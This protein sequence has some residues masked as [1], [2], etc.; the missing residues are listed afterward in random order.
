MDYK[1]NKEILYTDFNSAACIIDNVMQNPKLKI[2]LKKATIFKFWSKVAGKKFEKYSKA[3]GL[4]ENNILTVACANASVSSELTMFKSDILKKI[5]LYSKPLGVEI[6]DII[7]SHKIWSDKINS[8]N[9]EPL[10]EPPNP[11]KPDLQGFNPDDINLAPEE[12]ELIKKSVEK[13]TF[14]DETQRERMF[15]AIILNLKTQKY[16]NLKKNV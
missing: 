10:T 14:A 16:L 9:H 1:K 3:Q 6:T 15:K 8:T 5:N 13:N 7:F 11:Y 2:G 12:I 4:S